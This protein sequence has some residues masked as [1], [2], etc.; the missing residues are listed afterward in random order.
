MDKQYDFSQDSEDDYARPRV[1]VSTHKL[2][3]DKYCIHMSKGVQ[4]GYDTLI[5]TV[6]QNKDLL[7]EVVE[8][9]S[10]EP[11]TLSDVHHKRLNELCELI[12]ELN[13]FP[14]IDELNESSDTASFLMYIKIFGS[15]NRL[16]EAID[17]NYP[18][19]LDDIDCK[20]SSIL[21][22]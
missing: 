1:S 13:R 4:D 8:R 20:A 2:M 11:E 7:V 3:K 18:E 15:L 10:I 9:N 14:T 17:E 12:D 5:Q 22:C 16:L 21:E 6:L 19:L